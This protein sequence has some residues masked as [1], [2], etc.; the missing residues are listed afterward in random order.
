MDVKSPA[1]SLIHTP[2]VP[3]KERRMSRRQSIARNWQVKCLF[4]TTT[5]AAHALIGSC[6][7]RSLLPCRGARSPTSGPDC[8]AH[9][10]ESN[11]VTAPILLASSP[12]RSY[13]LRHN[14]R[15]AILDRVRRAGGCWRWRRSLE[16]HVRLVCGSRRLVCGSR[17]P[18]ICRRW[19]RGRD[20]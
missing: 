3:K 19:S 8:A 16:E 6:S 12:S 9:R 10:L 7:A 14:H 11:P 5:D 1:H 2:V 13:G 20:N 15:L 4:A 17:M 18:E